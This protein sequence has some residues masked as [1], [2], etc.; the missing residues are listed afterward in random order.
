MN[1][2]PSLSEISSDCHI[3]KKNYNNETQIDVITPI[4]EKIYFSIFLLI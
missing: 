1:P 3:D 2:L 4:N